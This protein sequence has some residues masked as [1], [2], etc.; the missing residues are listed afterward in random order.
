MSIGRTVA[1]GVVTGVLGLAITGAAASAAF[2]PT[3]PTAVVAA[4][5]SGA[6]TV[7]VAEKEGPKQPL[8][9]ILDRLVANGTITQAQEEAIL[10]AVKDAAGEHRDRD[11]AAIVKRVLADLMRL[12]IQYIDLPKEAVMGQLK[13]GKTLGEVADQRPGKS[14]DGLIAYDVAQVSAQLD[15]LVAD[16]KITQEKAD[17]IKASLPERV[18]KFVDHRF[19]P[20]TRD[21]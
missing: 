15:K 7:A 1:T 16:G 8:K 6:E 13:A 18:T 17:Q 14:R 2:T 4:V 21:K 12:S 5:E 11:N 9:A 19:D 3:P 10:K 20:K